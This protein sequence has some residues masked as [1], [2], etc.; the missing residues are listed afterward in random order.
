[1]IRHIHNTNTQTVAPSTKAT[2]ASTTSDSDSDSFRKLFDSTTYQPVA[3]SATVTKPPTAT[4]KPVVTLTPPQYQ[5]GTTVTNPD[6]SIT[7]VNVT[8]F[9]TPATAQQIAAKLGGTVAATTLSG[10]SA[11]QL[12][13]S[14]PGS[15]NMVNAG[16]AADLFARYGDQQGSQAWQIINRDLG[17]DPM[18]T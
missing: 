12:N 17:R 16:L 8:E 14:V 13:I 2:R 9:A 1:M 10:Y 6:G 11:G 7:P 5:Q 4:T 18:S 15:P 3:I